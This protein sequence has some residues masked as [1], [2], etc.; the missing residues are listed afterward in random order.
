MILLEVSKTFVNRTKSLHE[1]LLFN[2]HSFDHSLS[3]P[4]I[5]ST[6][7]TP[8][9]PAPVG[10]W[11]PCVSYLDCSNTHLQVSNVP[12][13]RVLVQSKQKLRDRTFNLFD[14]YIIIPVV[15]LLRRNVGSNSTWLMKTTGNHDM[16]NK[17]GPFCRF[18]LRWT[19]F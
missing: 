19:T 12:G 8:N 5:W 9:S 6:R 16:T 2:V 11:V 3:W 14:V 15:L 13:D 7:P 4:W 18:R 1:R 10:Q 17:R